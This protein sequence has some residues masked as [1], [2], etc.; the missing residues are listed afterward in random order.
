ML[1]LSN[2]QTNKDMWDKINYPLGVMGHCSCVDSNGIMYVF[3][4]INYNNHYNNH[5]WYL[6]L[7]QGS[8]F[9]KVWVD[10]NDGSEEASEKLT[11]HSI[12]H[13]DLSFIGIGASC[14][15]YEKN[16]VVYFILLFDQGKMI[17]ENPSQMTFA[18]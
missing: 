14:H 5:V 6:D 4:G 8:S 13:K 11:G 16:S 2:V 18:L 3:G 9:N 10:V 17:V 12:T 15:I 7:K 1:D